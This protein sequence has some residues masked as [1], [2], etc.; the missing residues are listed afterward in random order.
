MFEYNE[1]EIPTDCG[2]PIIV[3]CQVDLTMI[4]KGEPPLGPSLS[5][6]GD[7]G[8][9]PIFDITEIRLYDDPIDEGIFTKPVVVLTMN[10]AQFISF[11]PNGQDVV[12]NAYEWAVENEIIFLDKGPC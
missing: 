4:D 1:F 8:F 2:E 9:P 7:P 12:N 5:G 6:P 10:E 3:R 11:F